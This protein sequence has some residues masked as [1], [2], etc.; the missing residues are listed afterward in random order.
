MNTKRILFILFVILAQALAACGTAATPAAPAS[1]PKLAPTSAPAPTATPEPADPAEI[2]Q[3]F[4]A[5]MKAEDVEA[6]MAFLAEDAK[7]RGV[8][9]FAGKDPFNA[10]LQ[11]IIKAGLTTEISDIAVEGD[12]VTYLYKVFRNG[13]VVEEGAERESMQVLDGK[14]ILWNN[15]RYVG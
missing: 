7:C 13:F 11:G 10:Y 5:A 15:L 9:Y 4:W 3:G 14:I 2:V 6:A 8:C 12:T 1:E